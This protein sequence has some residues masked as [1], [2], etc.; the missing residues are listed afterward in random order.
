MLGGIPP[1]NVCLLKRV[2]KLIFGLD[3][4]QELVILRLVFSDGAKVHRVLGLKLREHRV[5][6]VVRTLVPTHEGMH[7][8]LGIR[9]TPKMTD[10]LQECLLWLLPTREV[11]TEIV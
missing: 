6:W 1:S 11:E 2:L 9:P 7:G 5:R 4:I 8:I 3:A 10:V